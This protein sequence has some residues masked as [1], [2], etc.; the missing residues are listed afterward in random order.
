MTAP[1]DGYTVLDL[2][3]VISGPFATCILAEHGEGDKVHT[4]LLFWFAA[5]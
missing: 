5:I 3:T 1:L 2:S 4:S